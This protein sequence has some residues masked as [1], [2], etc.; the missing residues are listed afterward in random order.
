MRASIPHSLPT[1]LAAL[2]SLVGDLAGLPDPRGVTMVPTPEDAPAVGGFPEEDRC[3][4]KC[5]TGNFVTP[6]VLTKAYNLGEPP[7]TAKGNM[8]VAEFQGVMWDA[9]ALAKFSEACQL[10]PPV[11]VSRQIGGNKPIKCEVP[12]IGTEACAE[13]MLDIECVNLFSVPVSLLRYSLFLTCAAPVG[14]QVHWSHWW[15]HPTYRH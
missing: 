13:A 10:S 11:N 1:D 9:P 6:A 4:N 8:A 5:G 12:I 2:V 14:I 3:S 7:K 15:C